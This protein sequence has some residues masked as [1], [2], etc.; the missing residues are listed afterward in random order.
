MILPEWRRHRRPGELNSISVLGRPFHQYSRQPREEEL[1][2]G[3]N[4]NV[5]SL[6][7]TPALFIKAV[8]VTGTSYDM[9][10]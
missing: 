2:G 6:G 4:L 3:Q 8:G 5:Q 7:G 1:Q 9:L 10:A